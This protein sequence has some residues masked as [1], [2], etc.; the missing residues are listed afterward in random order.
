MDGVT[1]VNRLTKTSIRATLC[2]EK[3]YELYGIKKKFTGKQSDSS[4]E[5]YK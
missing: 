4:S 3:P 2:C 1:V 5:G